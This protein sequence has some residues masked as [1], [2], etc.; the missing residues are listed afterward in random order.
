MPGGVIQYEQ[1]AVG[2]YQDS[3]PAELQQGAL[4]YPAPA[5]DSSFITAGWQSGIWC[6]LRLR[7]R[8]PRDDPAGELPGDQ[9][10][11]RV[12]AQDD[13]ARCGGVQ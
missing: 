4:F 11:V 2:E 5:T 13:G 9:H 7:L 10:P 8:E 12:L 3:D 6:G 1:T